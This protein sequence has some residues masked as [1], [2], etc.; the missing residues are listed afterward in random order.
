MSTG[1][2][3]FMLMFFNKL[4]YNRTA[5]LSLGYFKKT[6]TLVMGRKREV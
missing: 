4:D 3:L 2:F 1:Y 6:E 5:S